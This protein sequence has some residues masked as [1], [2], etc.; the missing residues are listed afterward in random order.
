MSKK[1][2]QQKKGTSRLVDVAK[3]VG[4]SRGA[5]ARVLLGTGS[6]NIRVSEASAKKI[7]EAAAR[8]NYEPN[9]AAQQLKGKGNRTIGVI[10]MDNAPL[11]IMDRICEMERCAWERGY[12]LVL[13]RTPYLEGGRIDDFFGRLR[14]RNVEGLVVFDK[15]S[16]NQYVN[17]NNDEFSDYKAVFHGYAICDDAVDWGVRPDVA[18]GSR[19]ATEHLIERGYKRIGLAVMG[20]GTDRLPAWQNALQ[21]AGL[22]VHD[23]DVYSHQ[24]KGEQKLPLGAARTI[25]DQ[26]IDQQKVD[27]LIVENDFWAARILQVLHERDLRIPEDLAVVGYN[28][29]EFSE[30]T[31]PALTTIDENN[32]LIGRALID[33]MFA[34]IEGKDVP[35]QIV[36]VQPELIV[37]STT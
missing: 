11:V 4:M 25:V 19:L 37:R 26:M 6:G 5:V 20:D 18:E 32:A 35:E 17:D 13:C 33:L 15:V 34:H 14:N 36:S 1:S 7:K 22:E 30:F 23:G 8:L 2:D 10:T 12:D 9:L 31:T 24:R 28:N 27:A 29:L 3:E 16:R 21:A